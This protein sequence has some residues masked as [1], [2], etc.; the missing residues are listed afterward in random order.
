[1]NSNV[2]PFSNPQSMSADVPALAALPIVQAPDPSQLDNIKS[3]LDLVLL[4]I[5]T[6][7]GVGSE[8]MLQAATSLKLEDIVADRVSLWRLRQS[9]PLRKGQ[10]GRKKLDIEEARALVLICCHLA[11]Q[12]QELIRRAVALLE[13][14]TEQNRPPHQ[15]A[16]LGDYLDRFQ[17]TYEDRMEEDN[18]PNSNALN[19]LA[20]KLLIDLLFYSGPQGA[21]RLW[22]ALLER[23]MGSPS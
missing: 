23:S 7:T 5:E 15:A 1:M 11:K 21:R 13:Q 6:L 8:A 18:L 9:N 17:N 20:L 16:L 22:M 12:H 2:I 10:G 14:L 19:H 4:A 3:Q